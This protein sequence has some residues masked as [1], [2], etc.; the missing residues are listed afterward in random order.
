MKREQLEHVL[1]AASQIADDPDVVVIGSQSILAA[2]PEDRLPREATASME[3]DVAFFND[4]D[5]RKSDRVDGA[6]GELSSFH[7]MNG[8]YAQG[9]S[10]STA[11]LPQGWRDRLLLVESR[12]TQPGRGYALD[13]HDCVVSKLVAGREKGPRLRQRSDR[14]WADRPS[15][16]RGP[17]RNPGGRPSGQGAPPALDR[18]V[19]AGRVMNGIASRPQ[20]QSAPPLRS[21]VS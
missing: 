10:V 8:Y 16:S 20:Q 2:I 11:T 13:P 6:I 3:V 4:P 1:R 9:V 18:H 21:M 5:N 12:S 7:E 14:E 15:D 19:H 17:H